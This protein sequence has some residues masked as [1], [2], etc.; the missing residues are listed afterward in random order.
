LEHTSGILVH[1]YLRDEGHLIDALMRNK[2]ET[3]LLALYTEAAKVFDIQFD[4][5]AMPP[6]E[7]GF[8]DF[9]QMLGD[10]NKSI[11][12]ASAI[13][14]SISIFI[15]A[16]PSDNDR[17]NQQLTVLDIQERQLQIKKLRN[18]LQDVNEENK[19]NLIESAVKVLK[20]NNRTITR[21]S[22]FYKNLT[23]TPDV[24]KV[25]VGETG[26]DGMLINEE[27]TVQRK[28][29]PLFILKTSKLPPIIDEL[30]LIEIIAPVVDEGPYKWKGL[31]QGQPISFNMRDMYYK[32]AVM[33]ETISFKHG[34][35]IQCVLEVFRKL[36]EAGEEIITGYSV[37]VVIGTGDSATIE[38]TPQGSE[39]KQISK[40]KK[41]QGDMFNSSS[42]AKD[43]S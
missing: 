31:Y 29:F 19:S 25:G 7:G 30:A 23:T 18:D 40:E 2:C 43:F 38:E 15:S 16:L 8:K 28:E 12:S 27:S 41:A 4:I 24:K 10:N 34:S 36:D 37:P 33:S 17:L 5:Q 13:I 42:N 39:Y 21:R 3:E 35:K 9:W 26:S 6:H 32:D 20:S 11:T 14:A 22:N 1:Y